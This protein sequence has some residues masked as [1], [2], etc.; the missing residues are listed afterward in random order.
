MSQN[1]FV[2]HL[3]LIAVRFRGWCDSMFEWNSM[4]FNVDEGYITWYVAYHSKELTIKK[5]K[6][7]YTYEVGIFREFLLLVCM[8]DQAILETAE[9][10]T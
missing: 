1:G 5:I 9:H 10:R 2:L 3:S 7:N 8:C 6:M 4:K